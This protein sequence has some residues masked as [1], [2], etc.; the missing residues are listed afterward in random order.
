MIHIRNASLQDY[1]A[2]YSIAV[3]TWKHTYSTILSAEQF[4]YMLEMMYSKTAIEQQMTE[5]A[6][7]FLIAE[8]ESGSAIGFCSYEIGN[9]PGKT[10]IHKLYVLPQTHGQGL[11]KSFVKEVEAAA[12]S[13]GNNAILLNVNRFNAAYHFYLKTGFKNMGEVNVEI[14]NGYLMEDYIM[15]KT[16]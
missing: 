14:G 16:L 12:A 11:G 2:I 7:Q 15:E 9:E 6:H 8:Y 1:N 4:N 10:K 3:T 5:M 13:A